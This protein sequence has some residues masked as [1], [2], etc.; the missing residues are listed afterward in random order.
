MLQPNKQTEIKVESHKVAAM[1]CG[2]GTEVLWGWA[3]PKGE[4]VV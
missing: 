3:M 4:R 1:S 2:K